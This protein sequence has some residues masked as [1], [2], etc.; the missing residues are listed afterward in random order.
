M[1]SRVATVSENDERG[2][3]G[4]Q[5]AGNH[6]QPAAC[7]AVVIVPKLVGLA[8]L[9]ARVSITDRRHFMPFKCRSRNLNTTS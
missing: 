2:N 4:D 7:L 9:A 6:R 5:D 1:V 3:D 8:S